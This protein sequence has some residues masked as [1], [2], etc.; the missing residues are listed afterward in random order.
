MNV[1][2][3]LGGGKATR[4]ELV[5]LI[6][7]ACGLPLSEAAGLADAVLRGETVEVADPSGTL[8]RLAAQRGFLVS[9]AEKPG[10]PLGGVD[11][12]M[13]YRRADGT[14]VYNFLTPDMKAFMGRCVGE[15]K[16][17]GFQARGTPEFSVLLE[18]GLEIR[19]AEFF[20]SEDFE[21]SVSR[22]LKSMAEGTSSP[23]KP[24]W[25]FW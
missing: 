5:S 21:G 20:D 19:L 1:R 3:E 9:S 11:G 15:A 7:K 24:W 2:L 16:T 17:R 23:R 4:V 8:A 10:R 18:S 14:V 22:V 12:A 6:R 13:T 25:R